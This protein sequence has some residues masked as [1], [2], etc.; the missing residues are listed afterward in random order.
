VVNAAPE[1]EGHAI[2]IKAPHQ[3]PHLEWPSEG[4][5]DLQ[6]HDCSELQGRASGHFRSMGADVYDLTGVAIR[7]RFDYYRPRNARSVVLASIPRRLV[8]HE[9]DTW[10]L[11]CP[12]P[13]SSH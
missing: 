8:S 1:E 5:D 12:R 6:A 4:R 11:A 7:S 10:Q 9:V 3:R 2:G 13:I